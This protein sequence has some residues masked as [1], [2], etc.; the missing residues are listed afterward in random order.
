MII[1]ANT[2]LNT[3]GKVICFAEPPL[4]GNAN[5]DFCSFNQH[6]TNNDDDHDDAHSFALDIRPRE[7]N[8][9]KYLGALI[10]MGTCSTLSHLFILPALGGKSS[11][12]AHA[13]SLP[14]IDEMN[15]YHGGSQKRR[16]LELCLV[17]IQRVC[18]WCEKVASEI[19]VTT[20][21]NGANSA[22][23][24]IKS[25]YLEARLGAKAA[26]TGKIGGGATSKVYT[27]STFQLR[28]CIKDVVSYYNEYYQEQNRMISND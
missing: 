1:L 6:V 10:T 16:Q 14:F 13:F 2:V 5:Q 26:L 25:S 17:T 19:K 22:T 9:R 27:I 15:G 3:K 21:D 20:R 8:R 12:A 23:D 11:Y 24:V 28:S 18:Y 7:S 4:H